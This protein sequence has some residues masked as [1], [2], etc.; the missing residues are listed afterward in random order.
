MK[1]LISNEADQISGGVYKCVCKNKKETLLVIDGDVMN[2]ARGREILLE[3]DRA[4]SVCKKF[5]KND[6]GM[7]GLFSVNPNSVTEIYTPQFSCLL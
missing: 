6:A 1:N 7:L 3:M 5:C 4:Y 2:Y